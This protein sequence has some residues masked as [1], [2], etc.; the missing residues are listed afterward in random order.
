MLKENKVKEKQPQGEAQ[1]DDVEEIELKRSKIIF[2]NPFC[3]S[4]SI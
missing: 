1:G 4:K 3:K 2:L